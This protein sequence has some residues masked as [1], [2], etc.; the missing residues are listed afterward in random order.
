MD[1]KALYLSLIILVILFLGATRLKAQEPEKESQL[2]AEDIAITAVVS[3]HI[4]YQGVLKESGSLVTG[5]R[6]M[7]FRFYSNSNCATEMQAIIQNGVPVDQGVFSVKLAVSPNLLNGQGLW[8][9][10]EVG[11]IAL[12]SCEEIVAV[13]YA[14]G[15]R[16]GVDVIGASPNDS[17]IYTFNMAN[18]GSPVGV[19]GRSPHGTGIS[20]EGGTGVYGLA[21]SPEGAGI[22]G[23]GASTG[24]Y[25]S[26]G[27]IGVHG[28]GDNIGVY[29]QNAST[30]GRGVYGSATNS[31]GVT[32]GVYGQAY[33]LSGYGG[34]FNNAGGGIALR[35]QSHT[36]DPDAP[37]IEAWSSS[38]REF[39]VTAEGSVHADE[40]YST[41]SEDFAEMLPAA[42]GLEPGE[43]LIID[44]EGK[45]ARSSQPYQTSVAG[46]Y[47]T[48][49]GFLGSVE[50]AGTL[51][52]QVPLALVG[53]VPVKASA[54]NGPIRPGDLLV[55]SATPG[56]AMKAGAI[57]PAGSVI[58][59]ALTGLEKGAGLIQMLVMLQ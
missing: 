18:T 23:E 24:V 52:G 5:N 58:G 32:Y 36:A 59:K 4:S 40:K 28:E 6:N 35:V 3:N 8:L 9:R 49:P 15:L 31:S 57:P 34:S 26:S 20:G 30:S 16:P 22:Y 46:V 11:G 56:H 41:P 19:S 48:Q 44:L 12:V 7:V 2:Q 25:G 50:E 45:L 27:G 37:I 55:A 33:S 47:S 51:A 54:E 10:V 43:V 21:T 17:I 42:N 39:D 14:L 29:G 53:K 1:R 38:D 13:P